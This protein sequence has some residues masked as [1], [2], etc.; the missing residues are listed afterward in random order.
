VH[1]GCSSSSG[2]D[3]VED[4]RRKKA[5]KMREDGVSFGEISKALGTSKSTVER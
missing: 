1:E 3:G 5:R 2:G 4:V